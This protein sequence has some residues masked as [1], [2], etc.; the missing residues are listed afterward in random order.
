V[1][2]E[3]VN[4]RTL[5]SSTGCELVALM[6][7]AAAAKA[8][9]AMD[10]DHMDAAAGAFNYIRVADLVSSYVHNRADYMPILDWGCGYGQVTWLLERRQ[11]PVVS[12]DVEERAAR[13]SIPALSSLNIRQIREPVRLPYGSQSFGAV[14]S[15]GVLEH[16]PDLEG[17]LREVNR[18]LRQGGLFFIFMFP[19]RFSWAE[20]LADVRHISV[21]PQK[22]TFRQTRRI[23]AEHGFA[24]E[25]KWR[26]NFLPR[27]LTGLSLALK[28]LYGRYYRQ[29][30]SL[31]KVLANVPPTSFLSGVLEMI[32]RKRQ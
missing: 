27:N 8:V 10:M 30:E 7:M 2:T 20:W 22:Y 23:L 4:S 18:I 32:V 29:I 17:S 15:V 5:P 25:R 31:D 19:N 1:K 6:D 13:A 12:C 24:I 11:L 3:T 21:H 14:L 28:R 9:G 26:R 16:V